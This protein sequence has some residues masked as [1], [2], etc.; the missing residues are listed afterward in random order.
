MCLIVLAIH[1]DPTHRLVLIANRDESYARATAPAAEWE[2]APGLIAGRDLRG[3]GT[4]L[5]VT[6]SR[7]FAAVTNFHEGAPPRASAPSR[8]S[9]V[10]EFLKSSETPDEYLLRLM[11]EAAEFA[12][13]N[14]IVGDASSAVWFSNRGPARPV[15]LEPGIHGLSNHL[16]NTPWPKVEIAKRRLASLLNLAPAPDPSDLLDSLHDRTPA[17]PDQDGS[18]PSPLERALSAAFIVTPEYGTRSTSALIL[19]ASGPGVLAERTYERG[20]ADFSE[21]RHAL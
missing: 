2:D 7:R 20:S 3:G 10:S 16:L 11:P 12:G 15:H 19:T 21:V 13:F 6:R 4:W 14:L 5:G 18:A 1:P 8:G 9:L 17:P